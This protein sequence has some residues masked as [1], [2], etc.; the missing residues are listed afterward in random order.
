MTPRTSSPLDRASSASLPAS[1]GAHPQRGRPTLTSI[2]TSRT[3]PIT[4]ASTVG[5]GST[6]SVTRAPGETGPP[7]RAPGAAGGGA[8]SPLCVK[9]LVGQPEILVETRGGHALDL[10]DGRAGERPV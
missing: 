8:A 4:A 3:P 2:R 7:A 10:A 5:T 1:S 6:A 9:H